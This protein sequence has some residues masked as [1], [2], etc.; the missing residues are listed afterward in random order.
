[1]QHLHHEYL[2]VAQ[3]SPTQ[4]SPTQPSPTLSS[5]ALLHSH[6]EDFP[7]QVPLA[8]AS[9]SLSTASNTSSNHSAVGQEGGDSPAVSHGSVMVVTAERG[10]PAEVCSRLLTCRADGQAA[11]VLEQHGTG[12][13]GLISS[14]LAMFSI[15]ILLM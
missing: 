7:T 14:K 9:P 11:A 10:G 15:I 4:P 1:M 5:D 2:P 8:A 13:C 6:Y 3:D 12:V